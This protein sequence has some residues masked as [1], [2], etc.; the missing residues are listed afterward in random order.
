MVTLVNACLFAK[1]IRNI[2]ILTV[3]MSL[4]AISIGFI[5]KDNNVSFYFVLIINQICNGSTLPYL[6]LGQKPRYF[7]AYTSTSVIP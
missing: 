2:L 3:N 7:P 1:L 4:F 6:F 5:Q